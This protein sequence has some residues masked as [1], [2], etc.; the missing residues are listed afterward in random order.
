MRTQVNGWLHRRL[1]EENTNLPEAECNL[2]PSYDTKETKTWQ[3]RNLVQETLSA[4]WRHVH[5]WEPHGA[6]RD[7]RVRLKL[8]MA[9]TESLIL[10]WGKKIHIYWLGKLSIKSLGEPCLGEKANKRC[11]E[12]YQDWNKDQVI[13]I[14]NWV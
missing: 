7:S 1:G 11:T 12:S 10:L 2:P 8:L 4:S 13:L 6:G 14:S 9:I 3:K 5:D